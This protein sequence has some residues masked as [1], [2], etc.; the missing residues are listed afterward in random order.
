[1]M[2]STPSSPSLGSRPALRETLFVINGSTRRLLSVRGDDIVGAALERPDAAEQW[3]PLSHVCAVE[4]EPAG[5]RRTLRLH[6]LVPDPEGV[7]PPSYVAHDLRAA[8]SSGLFETSDDA[9]WWAEGLKEEVRRVNGDPSERAPVLVLINPFSGKKKGPSV[10]ATRCCPIFQAAGLKHEVVI[11][12]EAGEAKR[13]VSQMVLAQYSAIA[14]VGGDGILCEVTNGLMSRPDWSLATLGGAMPV[15]PIPSGTA[16][17]TTHTLYRTPDPAAAACH[18]IRNRV[19]RVDMFLAAQPTLRQ[20]L[21]GVLSVNCGIVSDVDFGSECIRFM[22]NARMSI[23]AL[24]KIASK[25]AYRCRV[26]YL[27]TTQTR[28]QWWGHSCTHANCA[29]CHPP[30][31]QPDELIDAHAQDEIVPEEA[32]VDAAAQEAAP[33]QEA[34]PAAQ[35]PAQEQTTPASSGK[36]TKSLTPCDEWESGIP[37]M[38]SELFPEAALPRTAWVT[39]EISHTFSCFMKQ[40]W[41][42]PELLT[43]PWCHLND[44]CMDICVLPVEHSYRSKMVKLFGSLQ[45][46]EHVN[47]EHLEYHKVR[48][49]TLESFDDGEFF[50]VDGEPV[51]RAPF[52]VFVARGLLPVL[53]SP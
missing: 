38:Y 39:R 46:G 9:E 41:I 32:P 3:L 48:A 29:Y 15:A 20:Y 16:N 28:Q 23:W 47:F 53:C 36:F 1:M 2:D 18:V 26:S 45:T 25:R 4:F 49:F 40:P 31:G 50:G 35:T 52:N 17:A 24:L 51:P 42:S 30:Q 21:W 27:P 13:I 14:C 11:T 43:T 34:A 6:C 19:K 33:V 7:V 10:W 12:R 8:S 5:R 37:E 22:G 44:G